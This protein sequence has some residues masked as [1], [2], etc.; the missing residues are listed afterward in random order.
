MRAFALG[1]AWLSFFWLGI[2]ELAGVHILKNYLVVP[3][4]LIFI[5]VLITLRK[6]SQSEALKRQDTAEGVI[7]AWGN[8][9]ITQTELIDGYKSNAA[10]YPLAGLVAVLSS[11]GGVTKKVLMA[12]D[13]QILGD[14]QRSTLKMHI[15]IQGLHTRLV[16][17]SKTAPG[18]RTVLG[19][20]KFVEQLNTMSRQLQATS[21]PR[22]GA[23]AAHQAAP[24]WYPNPMGKP[25]QSYWNG[26]TWD[27]RTLG[28]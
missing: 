18:L 4:F 17:S 23:L 2:G 22:P 21:A 16:Y 24:G 1:L 14:S 13:G 25:G 12:S 10:R 20:K 3:G 26:Q 15:T 19:S 8:A 28:V 7:A 6:W 5:A 27:N 9:R 11:S